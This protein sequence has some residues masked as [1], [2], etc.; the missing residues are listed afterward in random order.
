MAEQVYR[1]AFVLFFLRTL[2]RFERVS[3]P[4]LD[5]AAPL[6][7]PPP[8]PG[9]PDIFRFLLPGLCHLVAEARPRR[10]LL[11]PAVKLHE[12]LFSY[13]TYHWAIYDGFRRWL[14]EQ[15]RESKPFNFISPREAR[16]KM[17]LREVVFP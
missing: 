11:G 12:T 4:D 16:L 3:S 6:S 5:G 13:L 10:V 9:T 1:V 17:K 8:G 15:V 7:A 14:R 2:A